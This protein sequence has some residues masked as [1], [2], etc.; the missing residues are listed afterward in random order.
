MKQV[1]IFIIIICLSSCSF[2]EEHYYIDSLDLNISINK[3]GKDQYRVCFNTKQ[4]KLC[5]NYIDLNY[6]PSEMPSISLLFPISLSGSIDTVYVKDLW[7]EVVQYQSK[8][9]V[10]VLSTLRPRTSGLVGSSVE[11]TDSTMFRRPCVQ[12]EL[13]PFLTGVTINDEEGIKSVR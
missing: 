10:I 2:K 1:L 11:W 4:N 6:H 7:H 13:N 9:F 8:D 5:S 3:L 12:V